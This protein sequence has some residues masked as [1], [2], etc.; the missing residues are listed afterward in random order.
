M[1]Y[2]TVI[3]ERIEKLMRESYNIYQNN[4][5]IGG[6]GFERRKGK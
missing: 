2:S 3:K 1:H 4:S 5:G 6:A